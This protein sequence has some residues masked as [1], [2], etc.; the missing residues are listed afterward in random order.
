[1]ERTTIPNN[2][3]ASKPVRASLRKA[4]LASVRSTYSLSG[5]SLAK[6]PFVPQAYLGLFARIGQMRAEKRPALPL[7]AEGAVVRAPARE[8]IVPSTPA[9]L[10]A[11]QL[12]NLFAQRLSVYTNTVFGIEHYRKRPDLYTL[13]VQMRI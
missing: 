7:G 5:G 11:L 6:H 8:V 2:P 9:S 3:T 4:W 10:G 1:M 13:F 12:R